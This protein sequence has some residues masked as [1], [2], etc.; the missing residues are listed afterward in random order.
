[1]YISLLGR[2]KLVELNILNILFFLGGRDSGG[3]RLT[4]LPRNGPNGPG[5]FWKW[6]VAE[7]L[8]MFLSRKKRG[9]WFVLC[10]GGAIN[11][12]IL[13]NWN[14]ICKNSYYF[15]LEEGLGRAPADPAA[16]ERTQRTR[17]ILEMVR[18]KALIYV[19]ISK[20]KGGMICFMLGG[21][22]YMYTFK[23]K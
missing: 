13:E 9:A 18:S 7:R 11:I 20:K 19:L 5:S 15:F 14:N 17:K 16:P 12:C 1:M 4:R 6:C 2:G 21:G 10:W 8:F 23:L 22:K 3:P